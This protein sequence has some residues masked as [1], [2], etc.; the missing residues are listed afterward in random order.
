M[1]E[2]IDYGESDLTP[3]IEGDNNFRYDEGY[4][5]AGF[6]QGNVED[7]EADIFDIYEDET[8]DILEDGIYED[9]EEDEPL[10]NICP[11]CGE[12]VAEG[13]KHCKAC[14]HSLT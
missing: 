6:T 4:E 9:D 10:E 7:I 13:S 14:G 1:T 2:S 12:V 8:E 5:E 11:N 3:L